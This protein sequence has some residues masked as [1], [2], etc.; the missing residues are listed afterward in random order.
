MDP[1]PI[2]FEMP[3]A[4]GRYFACGPYK[5]SMSVASCE[6]MYR[7]EKGTKN[8]RHPHC[9]GCPVGALHAGEALPSASTL[10]Q[11]KICPRC[12]Q[13]ASRIV[14]GVCVS[15]INRQYEIERGIN[16]KG[17]APSRL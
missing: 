7:A 10:Y 13:P 15:C 2:Y 11:S 12:T 3:G 9:A 6:G 4:P 17:S 5:S 1:T 14:R 8:G 16:A